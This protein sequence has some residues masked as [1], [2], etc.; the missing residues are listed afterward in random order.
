MRNIINCLSILLLV[1]LFGGCKHWFYV[2]TAEDAFFSKEYTVAAKLYEEE[3][4]SS[5]DQFSKALTAT[6][7]GDAYRLANQT[8][9]AEQWYN[10]ALNFSNDSEVSYKYAQMLKSNEKYE[11][12]K[13]VFNEYSYSNP[14]Q[15]AKAKKQI[16][17]CNLA[18]EWQEENTHIEIINLWDINSPNSDYAP[19]WYEGKA[20]LFSSA[21]ADATGD[22]LMGWTG[23]NP[24]D[25]F[26][27]KKLENNRFETPT[28][29]ND[30]ICSVYSEG[31][32]TF[33]PDF[34]TIYFTR[35][36][37]DWE[38]NDYCNIFRSHRSADGEWSPPQLVPLFDSDSL[39]VGQPFLSPDG[40]QLYFSADAP[41]SYGDKDLYVAQ[42]IENRWSKPKN[43]GPA[44]NTEGYEGFPY[45]HSDGKLYFA[46]SGHMGMGGLDIFSVEK[47]GKTWSNVTNLQHP[48]NSAADDFSIVFDPYLDPSEIEKVETKGYFASTRKGG[49]GND[50]LYQFVVTIPPPVIE[51]PP[52]AEIDTNQITEPEE[53]TDKILLTVQ[54]FS[55]KLSDPSNAN[56]AVQ[57]KEPI[58]NAVVEILG[59]NEE[60]YL[61]ERLVSDG[62]GK[63]SL[64]I[65][66][67]SE[68]KITGSNNGYLANS[69]IITSKKDS[70]TGKTEEIN[71]ELILDKIFSQQEIVL[72]NIYYDLAKADI[73]ED[74]KPVLDKLAEVLRDNPEIIVEFGAHTDSRGNKNY[75]QNLSQERAQSVVNYLITRQIPSQRLLAKGYGESLL[76]N[77]CFDGADCTEEEHQQNRRTT[78]KV[79]S[80]GFREN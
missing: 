68:Y 79:V 38:R 1:V 67:S 69:T 74:A 59:L 72:D 6:K 31:T 48:V 51:E 63:S 71:V 32:A 40:K 13:R 76:V 8:T 44:I 27:S 41:D 53:L 10:R 12:A 78:F 25:L 28:I 23:E 17:S 47:E 54:V 75:N 42:K 61:A 35:C 57:G 9:K 52:V 21:R 16:R 73:R 56:S 50:D 65:E 60:N 64:E 4:E 36:G 15:R 37:S 5:S 24:A 77:D 62:K 30:T 18:M 49:T 7:I 22:K 34:K 29:L 39:N 45:I 70:K 20:L 66:V 58:S 33:T 80:R 19:V 26:V 2:Q 14:L 3:Y 46:S 11:E 55:K 43:L